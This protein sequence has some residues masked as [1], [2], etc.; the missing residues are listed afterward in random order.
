MA[1]PVVG[2]VLT[3]AVKPNAKMLVRLLASVGEKDT[4]VRYPDLIQALVAV[5]RDPVASTVNLAELRA[6]ISP[7]GFR[8]SLL[9]RPDEL[10]RLRVPALILWVTTTQSEGSTSRRRRHGWFPRRS[11]WCCPQATS[12]TWVTRRECPSCYPRSSAQRLRSDAC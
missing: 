12:R 10:R 6:G 3:R 8:R 5:G 1:T 11:S 9:V 7:T 2:D 4:I